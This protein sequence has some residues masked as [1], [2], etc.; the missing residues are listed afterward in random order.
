MSRHDTNNTRGGVGFFGLLTLVFITLKLLDV[1]SW[2]WAWVLA[3]IWMPIVIALIV[4]IVLL[5]ASVR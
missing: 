1:I 4:I 3:P 2:S 5:I